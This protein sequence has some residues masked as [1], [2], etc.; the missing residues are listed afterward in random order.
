MQPRGSPGGGR[1]DPAALWH[2]GDI[3]AQCASCKA[4]TATRTQSRDRV[5]SGRRRSSLLLGQLARGPEGEDRVR[6]GKRPGGLL[7]AWEGVAGAS[8]GGALCA[9]SRSLVGGGGGQLG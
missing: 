9:V 5:C 8:D 1:A 3:A 6:L 7:L 4:H 2:R